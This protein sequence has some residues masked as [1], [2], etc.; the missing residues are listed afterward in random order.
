MTKKDYEL[1]AGVLNGLSK[2]WKT[3]NQL[4]EKTERVIEHTARRLSMA[5]ESTNER[6]DSARFLTACGVN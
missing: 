3:I 1:I 6:F 4:D 5:L 2:E